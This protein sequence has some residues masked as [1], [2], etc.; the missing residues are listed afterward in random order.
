MH[1][2]EHQQWLVVLRGLTAQL[3]CRSAWPLC[4]C[5]LLPSTLISWPHLCHHCSFPHTHYTHYTPP[6]RLQGCQDGV[7]NCCTTC[8]DLGWVLCYFLPLSFKPW[9]LILASIFRVSFGLIHSFYKE[10]VNFKFAFL[11]KLEHLMLL[12]GSLSSSSLDSRCISAILSTGLHHLS[13]LILP[14]VFI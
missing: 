7:L 14:Y 4:S 9:I 1:Y 2:I 6:G 10:L 8:I 3:N 12:P 11:L 5:S 13:V